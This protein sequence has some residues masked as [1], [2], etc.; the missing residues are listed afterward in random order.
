MNHHLVQTKKNNHQGG[1]D[2]VNNPSTTNATGPNEGSNVATGASESIIA[3][4][5]GQKLGTLL[6]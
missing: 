6:K 4:E 5:D 3:Y 2:N 1:G